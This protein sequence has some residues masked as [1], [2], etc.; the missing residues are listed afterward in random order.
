MGKRD[1]RIDD[2]IAKSADFA[3]PILNHLRQLVH[4]ACPDV[5][6]TLKWSFP[7]FLHKGMLCSMASFKQHCSFGFWKESLI[8]GQD[9]SSAKL[10]DQAMGQ[11][12]RITAL[13][14]LPADK[15]LLGYIKAAAK[16]NEAGVKLP[17][18]PK[19]K[20][21]RELV[22]PDYFMAALQKNQKA[23]A[24]FEGF[25][26]S[27]KKEYVE[28]I[29]EAKGEDTRQRRIDTTLKWLVEGKSRNWK[30]MNC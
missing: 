28:W 22:I 10:K 2:Y 11:F 9:K 19:S 12:G 13:S 1:A 26:Y 17:P 7:H 15:V 21:K 20:E 27:Q 3:K 4:A 25:S 18:R 14:D 16:L 23:L 24:A 8:L 29:T 6:E 5:A 30:Y